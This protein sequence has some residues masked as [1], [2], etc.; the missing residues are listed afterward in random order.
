MVTYL[1]SN[2]TPPIAWSGLHLKLYYLHI[3][4]QVQLEPL[5]PVEVEATG[6]DDGARLVDVVHLDDAVKVPEP[7]VPSRCLQASTFQKKNKV[8]N[9]YG[10]CFFFYYLRCIS[11]TDITLSFLGSASP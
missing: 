5:V 8:Y 7:F 6:A 9:C 11:K 1:I 3:V 2:E 10:K 4:K